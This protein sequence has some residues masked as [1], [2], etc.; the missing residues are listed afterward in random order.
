MKVVFNNIG[1]RFNQEWVFKNLN[2]TFESP[3][4][5]AILGANGSGKSTLAMLFSGYLSPSEGDI[6][7]L[8]SGKTVDK[9]E[10]YTD[11]AFKA[12]YI[13]LIEEYTLRELIGFQ[14]KFKPFLDNLSTDNIIEIMNLKQ[15]ENKF[16]HHFSSGMK[17]RLK[18]ALS[19]LADTPIL[20]LD[21][22][23]SNLDKEGVNWYQNLIQKYK[24]DR[25]LIICS[26]N[27]IEYEFCDEQFEIAKYK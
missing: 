13:D 12:P 15:H 5:Y 21:E 27:K 22:P 20:L 9:D 8:F 4:S 18:L 26:N 6:Q 1:K 24:K 17:Q 2:F 10:I 11:I 7:Y 3:K 25:M 23:C 14:K 19:I 16:V